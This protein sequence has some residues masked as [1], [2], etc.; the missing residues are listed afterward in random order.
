MSHQEKGYPRPAYAWYMVGLLLVIYTFSFIDRQILGLLGPAI[1]ADFGISDTQFGLLTG[2]AFA[3]FYTAFGLLCA[4]IADSRSRR[5]LIAAGL[6]LWSLMTAASSLARS[7]TSLFLLRMGVGVGEAT[8]AP[9][10]NSMLADSFPKERLSTALSVYSMG[11]PVGSALAFIVG[12]AVIDFAEQMPDIDIPGYGLMGGWQKA[13][14]MV[15]IPGLLLTVLML[16]IKEPPR[17]GATGDA[18]SIPVR[19]VLR[20]FKSKLR[21]YAGVCIGVSMNAAL[22]FGSIVFLPFFFIRYH[23]MAP[24]DVGITFGLISLFTG[25]A[26]LLFG[27]WLADRLYKKGRKDAHIWALMSAPIGF[28]I[29]SFTLPFIGDTTTAWIVLG[30]SNF[31]INSPSGVAYASLQIIT[32]NQMRG[33]IISIYVMCT[34]IIGYGAGPF[35]LGFFTDHIFGDEMKL[36]LSFLLLALITVPV[37]ILSFLWGRKAYAAAVVEEEERLGALERS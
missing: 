17:K 11:I 18:A 20:F 31:F 14:L 34:S 30:I 12:G 3:V 15:G 29:P 1:K 4:R 35:A 16:T 26:G 36:N 25:P 2:F 9:A 32:P 37:G 10:A 13:F 24:A 27:G 5:G 19:D 22:G 7:F 21:A 23:A 8:L 28:A 6:F 33:Q